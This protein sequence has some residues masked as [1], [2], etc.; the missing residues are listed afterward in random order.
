M[1]AHA[2]LRSILESEPGFVALLRAVRTLE[3]PDGWVTAG[4]LRNVVWDRLHGFVERHPPG[5]VDVVYFDRRHASPEI[6]AEL[7]ARLQSLL[8]GPRWE[9]VNQAWIHESN[10]EPPY[11]S[12]V[13]SLSTWTETCTSVA[14]RLDERGAIEVLAPHGVDDLM[15]LVARPNLAFAN[16]AEVFAQRMASKRWPETWPRVRVLDLDEAWRPRP[17]SPPAE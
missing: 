11:A 5:D 12:T 3:L 14:A 2:E 8:P 16:A 7:T 9:V 10:D 13:D 1:G 4:A 6:D 15:R 17:E